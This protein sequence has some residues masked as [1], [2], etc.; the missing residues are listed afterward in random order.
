MD[1]TDTLLVGPDLAERPPAEDLHAARDDHAR[2]V[3]RGPRR[4][5]GERRDRE[6]NQ[7]LRRTRGVVQG[8]AGS[9]AFRSVWAARS[10]TLAYMLMTIFPRWLPLSIYSYAAPASP[11]GKTR[12]MT[13]RSMCSAMNS[14]I[15]SNSVREPT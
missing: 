6:D 11:N 14:F 8:L 13:G 12:S 10:G 4:G 15:A 9:W 7:G 1:L 2:H 3:G 5:E